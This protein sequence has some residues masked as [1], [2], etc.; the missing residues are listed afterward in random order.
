LIDDVVLFRPF[1][2]DVALGASAEKIDPVAEPEETDH[3]GQ[4]A[5]GPLCTDQAASND[6]VAL[7]QLFV[8]GEKDPFFSAGCFSYP[9]VIPTGVQETVEPRQPEKAAEAGHI[10][11][12]YEGDRLKGFREQDRGKGNVDRRSMGVDFQYLPPGREVRERPFKVL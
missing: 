7:K 4:L 12:G 6:P 9:G 1:Q 10:R 3:L 11:I 5:P 8:P 2:G